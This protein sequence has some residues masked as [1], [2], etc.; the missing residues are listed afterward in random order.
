MSE[1]LPYEERLNQQWNDLPMPDVNMAWDDMRRRLEEDDDDRVIAWWRRG[2]LPWAI[3]LLLLVAISW[4]IFQPKKWFDKN[5]TSESTETSH[6]TKT[7]GLTPDSISNLPNSNNG[8]KN[9]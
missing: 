6:N 2:C 8:Q 9:N 5:Q 3:G 4:W 1:R 7:P